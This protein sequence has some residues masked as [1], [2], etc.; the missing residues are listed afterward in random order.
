M[1]EDNY[2]I[3]AKI[4]LE[5]AEELLREAEILFENQSYKSANN[6]AYYVIEKSLT[7]LLATAKIQTATHKG[8]LKQF[9]LLFVRDENNIFTIDDYKIA[10]KAE[11]IRNAS[12]YDDFYIASKLESKEQVENAKKLYLKIKEYIY[13]E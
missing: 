10:A 12:D 8:C 11:Q 2:K 1:E 9:N 7:A 6:R 13:S 3:L 5:R 4:R